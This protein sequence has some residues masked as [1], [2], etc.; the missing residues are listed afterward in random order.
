VIQEALQKG[1]SWIR[2]MVID[3][4]CLLRKRTDQGLF[5]IPDLLTTD[6]H[7]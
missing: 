4:H 5:E 6:E 1:S 7:G 2:G 3:D